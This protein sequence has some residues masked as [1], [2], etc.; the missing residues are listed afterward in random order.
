MFGLFLEFT[1]NYPQDRGA[2]FSRL[3]KP[4]HLMDETSVQ[5]MFDTFSWAMKNFDADVFFNKSILVTPSNEHFPGN[6]SS[7]EGMA[8]LIF[9]R[10]KVYAG[11]QHW[12]CRLVDA[13]TVD[14]NEI[15]QIQVQLQGSP[16]S[17]TEEVAPSVDDS[18][19][20]VIL[21]QQE[22]LRDPEVLIANFAHTLAHYLGTTATEAPPG[23]EENWPHVTELLAVFMGFG[24]MMANSANTAKIRSCSSCS[25]PAVERENFL[26]EYD[27]TYALAI[28]CCLKEIPT[29]QVVKELKSSLRPFYK[30]A[31][32]DVTG[33]KSQLLHLREL[34]Q[35]KH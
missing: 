2:M 17:V 12:P 16:R 4:A 8:S 5:W 31:V 33:R 13:S 18:Q 20:L 3:F 25:G 27:I 24:V 26:S 29:G 32:K 22:S 1:K 6:V 15:P 21:Y 34:Q 10:V 9:D 19:K 11:M 23:G 28:F 14:V 30:R 7:A 35:Q